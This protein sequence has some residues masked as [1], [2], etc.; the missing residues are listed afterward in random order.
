MLYNLSN[1]LFSLQAIPKSKP[2]PNNKLLRNSNNNNKSNN[3]LW[4]QHYFNDKLVIKFGI[5]FITKKVQ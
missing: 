5:G 1:F 2:F 4:L 3:N